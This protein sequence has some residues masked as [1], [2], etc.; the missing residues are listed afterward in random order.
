[1]S[2]KIFNKKKKR[3]KLLRNGNRNM[4]TPKENKKS[5]TKCNAFLIAT[6]DTLHKLEKL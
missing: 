4:R 2:Q 5:R 6:K 1:M 3:R